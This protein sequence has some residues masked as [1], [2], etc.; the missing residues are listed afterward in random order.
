MKETALRIAL[1]HDLDLDVHLPEGLDFLPSK[2]E[3]VFRRH[4]VWVKSQYT[5]PAN[6]A[7]VVKESPFDRTKEYIRRDINDSFKSL[8]SSSPD[9]RFHWLTQRPEL[10]SAFKVLCFLSS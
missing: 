3:V 10:F 4:P 1:G 9:P 7:M 2:M 8:M 6:G 5:N